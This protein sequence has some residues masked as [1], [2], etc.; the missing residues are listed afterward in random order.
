M[1]DLI[2]QEN[3]YRENVGLMIINP[4]GQVFGGRRGDLDRYW[5][6]PQGGV[7]PGE[8]LL[9]AA[10]RE[11]LEEIGT[12]HVEYIRRSKGWHYYDFP[13][14]IIDRLPFSGYV[15][16]K[17]RWLAFSFE[18]EDREICI[19]TDQ[20]EF[21]QWAWWPI[22]ELVTRVIPFKQSIYQSISQ[23]FSDLLA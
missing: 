9:D 6:M 5:Q 13:Q 7:D 18:G 8:L 21:I 19:D 4:Q 15:G 17:Q 12:T 11:M 3:L 20:P 1:A 2:D 14:E 16:Q 23:E 22:A 10:Y